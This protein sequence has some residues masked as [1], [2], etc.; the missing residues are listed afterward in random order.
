MRAQAARL[1]AFVCSCAFVARSYVRLSR[2]KRIVCAVRFARSF[3]CDVRFSRLCILVYAYAYRVVFFRLYT[4]CL[5]RVTVHIVYRE[6]YVLVR[7]NNWLT[8]EILCYNCTNVRLR[9]LCNHPIC[10]TM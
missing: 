5:R 3:L 8:S 6:C 10:K 9:S 7:M 2:A 4:S 1:R